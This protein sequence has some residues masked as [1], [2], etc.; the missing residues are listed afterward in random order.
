MKMIMSALVLVSV[1]AFASEPAH[2]TAAPAAPAHA[3]AAP[4]AP[5]AD[6]KMDK[7]TAKAKVDCKDAKNSDKPECAKKH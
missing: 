7:K 1:S 3:T 2:T 4:A 5:A 6:A